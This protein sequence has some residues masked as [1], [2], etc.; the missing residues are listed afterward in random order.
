M[1]L[2]VAGHP[3]KPSVQQISVEPLND[4]GNSL[5]QRIS[6]LLLLLQ[7]VRSLE[8]EL[9]RFLSTYI[10]L[11]GYLDD[12]ATKIQDMWSCVTSV[13]SLIHI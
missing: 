8:A 7:A 6:S 2:I 5:K 4:N 10:I 3:S 1:A 12:A 11:S 13:L 9:Q